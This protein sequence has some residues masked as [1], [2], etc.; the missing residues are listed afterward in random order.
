MSNTIFLA[1]EIE[2]P[3]Y[4]KA[5]FHIVPVPYEHSVSY[6]EG[7][8]QGP[9]SILKASS[10]LETYDQLGGEP[11]ED[12]IY[13]HSDID[14][15]GDA[16]D[17]MQRIRQVTH[18]ITE[19]GKIPFVLGGEHSITFGAV[20][21]VVDAHPNEAIGVIQFDAHAD[22]RESYEGSIWSHACVMKRLTD[23]G[24]RIFQLGIRA[25]SMEEIAV[26]HQFPH[27]IQYIDA[28]ILCNPPQ[29]Q[30]Q[31]PDDFPQKVYIT[32]DIDGL[33]GAIMPATGTP[34]SGGLGW[35]QLIDL[36]S[37]IAEQRQIVGMDLVE[38]APIANHHAYDFAAADLAYKMMGIV[39]RSPLTNK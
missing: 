30:F 34:V 37:S 25:I 26:R 10:Q 9:S 17:V 35:W 12:G 22:L 19:A 38:F 36:L 21:G 6:G 20:M 23:E 11:H 18:I 8:E 5:L 2:Q 13:T 7:T 39:S 1:S 4:H 27:Q 31:L 15:R 33:D 32:V 29:H 14:C 3:D 28:K 16:I 24:L